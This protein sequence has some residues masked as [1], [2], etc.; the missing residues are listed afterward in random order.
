MVLVQRIPRKSTDRTGVMQSGGE[1]GCALGDST[2]MQRGG[3]MGTNR[4]IRSNRVLVLGVQ[5]RA[6]EEVAR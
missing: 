3:T 1:A 4:L 5:D 6:I 2:G